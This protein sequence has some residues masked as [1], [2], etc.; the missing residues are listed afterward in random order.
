MATLAAVGYSGDEIRVLLEKEF[1]PKEFFPDKGKKLEDLKSCVAELSSILNSSKSLIHKV[2]SARGIFKK[3]A[4]LR[5]ALIEGWGLYDGDL[6]RQRLL[7]LIRTKRPELR[8]H[9]DITF[10]HLEELGCPPLKIVASDITNRCAA[11]FERKAHKVSRRNRV[12]TASVI[13]AVRASAGYPFLFE[14]VHLGD[15]STLI[16]GGLASNLPSFLFA[17]EQDQTHFG[18]HDL[19]G[20]PD[21]QNSEADFAQRHQGGDEVGVGNVPQGHRRRLFD[22]TQQELFQAGGLVRQRMGLLK[23]RRR[24]GEKNGGH[25]AQRP[26]VRKRGP[27]TIDNVASH[28][29]LVEGRPLCR[30]RTGP[31]RSLD[32]SARTC[33]LVNSDSRGMHMTLR[34]KLRAADRPTT[35]RAAMRFSARARGRITRRWGRPRRGATRAPFAM[36]W[37]GLRSAPAH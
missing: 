25:G 6:L 31:S 1:H 33:N 14:P 19:R 3:N 11:V 15:Q 10:E 12:H 20:R 32:F 8:N 9:T 5:S 17:D 13:E 21:I 18:C 29:A 24:P 26:W 30:P 2:W 23:S 28:C 16:D 7:D 37:S 4:Q 36:G 34:E 22:R 27:G 35:L